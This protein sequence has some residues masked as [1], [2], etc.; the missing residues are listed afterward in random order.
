MTESW[1]IRD[2]SWAPTSTQCPEDPIGSNCYGKYGVLVKRP[3]HFF[4]VSYINDSIIIYL[5][6]D[7]FILILYL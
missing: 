7:I 4:T 5:Y 3:E 2:N 6:R 1:K